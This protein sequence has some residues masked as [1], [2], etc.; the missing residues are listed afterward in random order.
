MYKYIGLIIFAFAMSAA[1]I[2]DTTWTK[3]N[4]T[5]RGGHIVYG[6][7]SGT[8]CQSGATMNWWSAN[9]WCQ[10][11]GGKLATVFSAC[12]FEAPFTNALCPN[13]GIG[14]SWLEDRGVEGKFWTEIGR[15][16]V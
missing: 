5:N 12:L 11:H 9:V 13:L 1:P 3:E 14:Q 2:H 8:F 15:A 7:T 4:C 10:K 6:K 16:H